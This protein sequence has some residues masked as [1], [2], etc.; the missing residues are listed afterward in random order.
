MAAPREA[1]SVH[2]I[3][4][5]TPI[6]IEVHVAKDMKVRGHTYVCSVYQVGLFLLIEKV[7]T[8]W[9]VLFSVFSIQDIRF[10][11]SFKGFLV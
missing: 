9:Y 4:L 7:P 10:T 6:L 3:R 8:I 5:P 2:K 1:I 11:L